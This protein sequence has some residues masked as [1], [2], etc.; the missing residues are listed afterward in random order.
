MSLHRIEEGHVGI[1][2]R[3]GAILKEVTYP[4]YNLMLPVITTVHQIQTTMQTDEI[5]NIPC[6]KYFISWQICFFTQLQKK[7][8]SRKGEKKTE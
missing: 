2:Y 6:G 8:F 5:R 4:G 1:Y 3:G 7:K